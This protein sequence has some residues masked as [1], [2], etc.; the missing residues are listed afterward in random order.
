MQLVLGGRH[1]PP[2]D[3]LRESHPHVAVTK[4]SG[5]CREDE[6]DAMDSE[7]GV[8]RRLASKQPE[9]RSGHESGTHDASDA[10]EQA[11][12]RMRAVE[13]ERCEDLS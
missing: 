12:H 2:L 11:L 3:G 10:V 13:G 6:S 4:I 9:C 8:L 5:H 1:E 7:N